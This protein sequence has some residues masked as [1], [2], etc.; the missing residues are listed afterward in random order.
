MRR[1]SF[2]GLCP[3]RVNLRLDLRH[4][5]LCDLE[6][7]FSQGDADDVEMS[8]GKFQNVFQNAFSFRYAVTPL[9]SSKRM[10]M[11]S[12]KLPSDTL[13]T[14]IVAEPAPHRALKVYEPNVPV[15]T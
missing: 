6:R 13:R 11:A 1:R 8:F 4:D 15:V 7:Q 3:L 2:D 5:R 9:M 12:D 10:T 14:S